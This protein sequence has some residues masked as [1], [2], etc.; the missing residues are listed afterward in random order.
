M[1]SKQLLRSF[2]AVFL[3]LAIGFSACIKDECK[4]HHTYTYYVPI[5]KTNEEVRANIRS[6]APKEIEN[7]GKIYKYGNYILL[8]DVDRGIHVINN[9]NPA[10]P[11]K[12]AFI[13]IPGNVDLAVKDGILY[14][15]LY[16]DLVAINISDPMNAR[17]E[18]VIDG[19]FP[20]R[21]WS[22][23]FVWN[24]NPNVTLAG[25]IKKDTTVVQDCES[26][27]MWMDAM[28][29]GV[30]F[31]TAS[32]GSNSTPIGTGGSMARFTVMNQRLY[33]VGYSNL[34]VFNISD[35]GQPAQTNDI[36]LGWRV[37]TIYPFKNKLFI[38][39]AAGMFIYNVGNPDAPT[40]DAEFQHAEACDPVIADDTHAFITLR[41]GVSCENT[42]NQL[43]IVRLNN[44]VNPALVKV[45]PMNNPHGLSKSGNT[46]FI[47]DGS[48]G[49]KVYDAGDVNNLQ[50]LTTIGDMNAYDVIA[51][52]NIALV[53]AK[54]GLLQYDYSNP[55]TL[56]L[57]SKIQIQ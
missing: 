17:V 36:S 1:K 43:E 45:Y 54:E 55:S 48:Q 51:Q 10:A 4:Q 24:N 32:S 50:L 49:L 12:V 11:A 15:D 20:E 2:I 28:S 57:L 21:R 33:T 46:L 47:C 52:N 44:F 53:V 26:G 27:L 37:E 41:S 25:W 3:L 9:T 56:R 42:V 35:P 5:Y 40:R 38:G 18:K 14:A 22:N 6:N 8:N 34:G 7:P 30:F 29:P 13:D 31:S 16:T 39:S 19:V 23:G